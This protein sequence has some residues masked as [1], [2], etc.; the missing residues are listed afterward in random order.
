MIARLGQAVTR[1]RTASAQALET[2]CDLRLD[3]PLALQLQKLLPNGFPCQ[4]KLFCEFCDCCGALLLE[5]G[6]NGAPTLGKLV[7]GENGDLLEAGAG[8]VTERNQ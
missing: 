8:P 7:D 2:A 6:Q 5:R 3:P 4:L 1:C